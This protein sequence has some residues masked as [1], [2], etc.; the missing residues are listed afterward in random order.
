MSM[1]R[2]DFPRGF[3]ALAYRDFRLLFMSQCVSSLGAQLQAFTNTWLIF[4]LTGSA[5]Q[6]GLTGA[7]RAIPLICFSLVGGVL[8]DRFDR[9]R[10]ALIS[11]TIGGFSSLFLAV[12]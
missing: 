11:Q 5:L 1:A 12:V 8:A 3:S 9:R 4:V 10:L 7:A 6:I 2:P